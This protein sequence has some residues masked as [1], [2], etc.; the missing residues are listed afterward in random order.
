[1]G[2]RVGKGLLGDGLTAWEE[3]RGFSVSAQHV[4]TEPL[5]KDLFLMTRL[6][7]DK[8]DI[9]IGCAQN[10][11]PQLEQV[12]ILVSKGAETKLRPL[13]VDN[14]RG[15]V[16]NFN[17][18]NGGT[19]TRQRALL[20]VPEFQSIQEKERLGYAFLRVHGP[21][22]RPA[23]LAGANGMSETEAKG[24]DLQLVNV[25]TTQEPGTPCVDCGENLRIDSPTGGEDTRGRYPTAIALSPNETERID[26][27][28]EPIRNRYQTLGITY[29]AAVN[30]VIGHEVGHGV[31]IEHPAATPPVSVMVPDL[32]NPAPTTYSADDRAQ[33]RLHIKHY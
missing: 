30:H 29:E 1:L 13:E 6:R 17:N 3:Y 4:R 9:G 28:E 21:Q 14:V 15:M 22:G 5:R 32:Q 11:L 7:K 10:I 25:G 31:H 16:V 24:D 33:M 20:I 8:T 23:V 27:Y 18:V 2:A 19:A 12:H 26:I